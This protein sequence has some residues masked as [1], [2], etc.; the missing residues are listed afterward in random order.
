VAIKAVVT[1]AGE[2]APIWHH[3]VRHE[4]RPETK[5]LDV[6]RLAERDAGVRAGD[7]LVFA[8]GVAAASIAPLIGARL[9]QEVAATVFAV[10]RR[11][12]DASAIVELGG[13]DARIVI[14]DTAGGQRRKIVSLN[15]KCAGGTGVVID[16]IAAKLKIPEARL[17]RLSYDGRTI[18]SIAGKCGVFAETDINGLQKRGV[19]HDDLMASLFDAIV[20]QNLTV[21]AR[22][23]LLRPRVLLLGG[24]HAF[25]PALVRPGGHLRRL[26]DE[27][28]L[29]LEATDADAILAP[30]LAA[31]FGALGAIDLGLTEGDEPVYRGLE[32]LTSAAG[33]Q[34]LGR[35]GG[36]AAPAVT[37]MPL[38]EFL[39]AYDRPPWRPP[40]LTP[41]SIVE[42]FIGLDAG[43]TSTKAVVLDEAGR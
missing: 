31:H 15:D 6:L 26:W 3:Y 16:K 38:E 24:P 5:V 40:A 42:G 41:G 14:I 36:A 27:R 30:S 7:A 34:R 23:Q 39:D 10:E 43:S 35:S 25:V 28:Q 22:G 19:P 2:Q 12:P 18:Y 8:T 9:V 37:G 29:P 13:Q 17:A 21:L 33:G 1:R 32:A 11:Y 20:V 4:S